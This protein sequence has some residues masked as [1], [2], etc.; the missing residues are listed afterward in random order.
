MQKQL[1]KWLQE[2]KRDFPW[3]KDKIL[4]IYGSVKYASTNDDRN[5]YTLL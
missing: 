2:N 4:I 1:I 3:R 5:G